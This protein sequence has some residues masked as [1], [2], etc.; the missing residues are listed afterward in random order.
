MPRSVINVVSVKQQEK[1]LCM[2][3]SRVF[4]HIVSKL[5]EDLSEESSHLMLIEC[6]LEEADDK[7]TPVTQAL[8]EV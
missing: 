7:Q 1:D 2:C 5:T 3:Q 8:V 6:N 4:P